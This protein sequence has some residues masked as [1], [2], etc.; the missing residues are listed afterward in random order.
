MTQ[1]GQPRFLPYNHRASDKE[2]PIRLKVDEEKKPLLVGSRDKRVEN[3]NVRL[4]TE[5]SARKLPSMY[6]ASKCP[7]LNTT[8]CLRYLTVYL[9]L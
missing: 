6:L 9:E 2:T 4:V 1:S 3:R 7:L 8:R 5:N